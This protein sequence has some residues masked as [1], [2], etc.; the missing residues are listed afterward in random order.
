MGPLVVG[1]NRVR[2]TNSRKISRVDSRAVQAGVGRVTGGDV[3]QDMENRSYKPRTY[4]SV[5]STF[6]S[7]TA[8]LLSGTLYR[9]APPTS[10]RSFAPSE[11]Q[12]VVNRPLVSATCAP[13]PVY[14]AYFGRIA[15]LTDQ[16]LYVV[17]RVRRRD[18]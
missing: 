4:P 9:C 10:G 6:D 15:L 17:F 2:C 1:F 7:T 8:L 13:N 12:S 18:I 16:Y 5:R 11:R 14:V 3:F